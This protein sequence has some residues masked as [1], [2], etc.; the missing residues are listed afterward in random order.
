MSPAGKLKNSVL[1]R[2]GTIG[3]PEVDLGWPSVATD[4]SGNLFVTYNRA[5]AVTGEF[6]SAWVAEIPPGS[7]TATQLL[8][9]PGLATYDAVSGIERWGDFTGIGRDPV[10]PGL[11]ATFNQYALNPASW[12]QAVNVVQHV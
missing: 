12:Q 9:K 2:K 10:T 4:G 1:A 5:S 8:L 7:T 6:L 3:A 11:V